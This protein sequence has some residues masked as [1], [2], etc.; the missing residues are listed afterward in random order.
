M[1]QARFPAGWDEKRVQEVIE[2]YENQT[3]EEALAEH[4]HALEEQKET[5]VDVPVE[6]LPFVREL[7][8]KFRESRDSRD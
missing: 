6:L 3:D 8:A 7:I 4:E 2:H 5:L 1:K